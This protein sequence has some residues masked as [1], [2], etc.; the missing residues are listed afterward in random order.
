MSRAAMKN[1]QARAKDI[2]SKRA[3]DRRVAAVDGFLFALESLCGETNK[4]VSFD[5]AWIDGTADRALE[6]VT[7]HHGPNFKLALNPLADW[8]VELTSDL[9]G[10][11][12][13]PASLPPPVRRRLVEA[14][15]VLLNRACADTATAWRVEAEPKDQS[16]YHCAWRTYLFPTPDGLLLLHCSID[17]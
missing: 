1:L 8:R 6:A 7:R 17:D 14:F 2:L 16:Y 15:V 9:L 13:L 10:G 11:G 4:G 3:A 12:F 5:F